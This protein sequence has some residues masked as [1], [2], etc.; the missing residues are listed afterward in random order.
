MLFRPR[1]AAF[2]EGAVGGLL[3]RLLL[4]LL[5]RLEHGADGAIGF[6][7]GERVDKLFVGR[8][9]VD[10][11]FRAIGIAVGF[12]RRRRLARTA[13]G[14]L[15]LQVADARPGGGLAALGFALLVG[16]LVDA[17]DTRAERLAGLATRVLAH[18]DLRVV[19]VAIVVLR[20][21]WRV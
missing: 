7:V 6:P 1:G 10:G 5:L 17:L 14:E 11:R 3:L 2:G 9:V 16:E 8:E 4:V 15:R 13:A 19:L 18:A 12:G 20:G 21:A